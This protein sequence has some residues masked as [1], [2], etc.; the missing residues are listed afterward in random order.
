MDSIVQGS[1]HQLV[2]STCGLRQPSARRPLRRPRYVQVTL[3]HR[4]LF[5]WNRAVF[6]F[7]S[8][9]RARADFTVPPNIYITSPTPSPIPTQH[10]DSEWHIYLPGLFTHNTSS[11]VPR[12]GAT[13]RASTLLLIVE[14]GASQ[15]AVRA[16]RRPPGGRG[17]GPAAAHGRLFSVFSRNVIAATTTP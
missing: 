3:L 7:V 13:M 9:A 17:G 4:L 12:A 11:Y 5:V 6:F 16:P 10:D 1:A 14:L 2:T 8:V 15:P